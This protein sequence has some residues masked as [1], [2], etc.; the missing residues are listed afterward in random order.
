[1][2]QWAAAKF[3]DRTTR[4]LRGNERGATAIELLFCGIFLLILIAFI[5]QQVHFALDFT[6]AALDLR[7]DVL[8]QSRTDELSHQP[9]II[10]PLSKTIKLRS[11]PFL[12]SYIGQDQSGIE[13]TIS[14]T[15]A[16]G[17]QK[18]DAPGLVE[19]A[20]ELADNPGATNAW[21]LAIAGLPKIAAFAYLASGIGYRF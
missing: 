21:Q 8:K 20:Y 17:T 7:Y 16:G 9:R 14:M 5:V 6:E 2:T 3:N 12:S 18:E 1:M 15:A 10:P 19:V 11:S 4:E 13:K